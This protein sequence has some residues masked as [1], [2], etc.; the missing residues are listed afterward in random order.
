MDQLPFLLCVT[1]YVK[2]SYIYFSHIILSINL[3]LENTGSKPSKDIV[4]RI[5][6]PTAVWLG[7]ERT[8]RHATKL[9]ISTAMVEA[10]AIHVCSWVSFIPS[11][12][13]ATGPLSTTIGFVFSVAPE[14]YGLEPTATVPA[15]AATATNGTSAASAA[16]A[17]TTTTTAAA[18]ANFASATAATGFSKDGRPCRPKI[19]KFDWIP[20]GCYRIWNNNTRGEFKPRN[21]SKQST[22]REEKD[23]RSSFSGI[24]AFSLPYVHFVFN[25]LKIIDKFDIKLLI[26]HVILHLGV[27]LETD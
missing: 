22:S 20:A 7:P 3:F 12:T 13:E 26:F 2:F 27:V 5:Y 15:G 6:E 1:F 25:V 23:P 19:S 18:A 10:N 17:I 21:R 8:T 11:S 16:N 9:F 24:L 14:P 4:T